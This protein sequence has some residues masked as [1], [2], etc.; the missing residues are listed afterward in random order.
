MSLEY[1]LIL[2]LIP[3]GLPMIGNEH[4]HVILIHLPVLLLAD[5]NEAGLLS[6]VEE[7]FDVLDLIRQRELCKEAPRPTVAS[8]ADEAA[9]LSSL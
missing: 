8:P 9:L 4:S 6:H 2:K 3:T 5:Y 1:E 7:Q